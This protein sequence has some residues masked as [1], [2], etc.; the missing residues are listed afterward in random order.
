MRIGDG[1]RKADDAEERHIRQ[2]V[3]HAGTGA[4]RDPGV[5]PQALKC[6]KLVARA[7]DHA[8]DAHLA[9]AH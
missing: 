7:L 6:G 5:A 4:R 8:L 2:V 9:A 3:A 1:E